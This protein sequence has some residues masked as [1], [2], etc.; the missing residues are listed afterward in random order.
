MIRHHIAQTAAALLIASAYI[1]PAH[2]QV[3]V[4]DGAHIGMQIQQWVKNLEEWQKD[5]QRWIS[6]IKSETVGKVNSLFT[7]SKIADARSDS[8]KEA[9]DKL[10]EAKTCDKIK[11][12]TAKGLC[13]D[14]QKLKIQRAQAYVKALKDAEKH[15]EQVQKLTAE[16]NDLIEQGAASASSASAIGEG[17][18]TKRAAIEAKQNEILTEQNKITKVMATVETEVETIDR[19]ITMVHDVR[20]EYAKT[21]VEGKKPGIIDKFVGTA[22]MF[23]TVQQDEETYKGKIKALKGA[24]GKAT[25][26]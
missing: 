18:D 6:N 15:V 11:D 14:E 10:Q 7:D 13:T 12:T 22:A 23:L 1:N 25:Q 4:G 19:Q 17:T 3:P 8:M 24:D 9:I 20:V 5:A 26:Y 16:L 2:A 21:Q